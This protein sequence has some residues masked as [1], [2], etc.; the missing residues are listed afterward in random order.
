MIKKNQFMDKLSIA[1]HPKNQDLSSTDLKQG[2]EIVAIDQKENGQEQQATPYNPF[3]LFI[4]FMIDIEADRIKKQRQRL[5]AERA[6]ERKKRLKTIKQAYDWKIKKAENL[7]L[8]Y[9][10]LANKKDKMELIPNFEQKAFLETISEN[11]NQVEIW[12][13]AEK[14]EKL[15]EDLKQSVDEI[16][17]G[18]NVHLYYQFHYYDESHEEIT[19]NHNGEPKSENGAYMP[20][21]ELAEMQTEDKILFDLFCELNDLRDFEP[22]KE[23]IDTLRQAL[24][25]ENS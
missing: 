8:A 15:S 22:N 14:V 21:P 18:S 2:L 24:K 9:A 3:S 12:L 17:S 7:K 11:L 19:C 23:E 20:T 16:T 6:E 25:A 10:M 13:L 4:E 5:E 1:V